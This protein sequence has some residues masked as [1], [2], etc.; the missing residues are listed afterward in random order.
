MTKFTHIKRP[1][2]ATCIE[3]TG[4]NTCIVI[5]QLFIHDCEAHVYGDQLMLRW[6]DD[7]R[8][9]SLEMMNVGSVLR[10][11]ENEVMK[12]MTPE[13]FKLKYEEI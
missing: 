11:G 4:D 8:K 9:P 7:F 13:E 5:E 2:H 6:K 1:Y 3:W 10:I 12:V